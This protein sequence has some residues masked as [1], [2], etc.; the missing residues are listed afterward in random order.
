MRLHRAAVIQRPTSW[1]GDDALAL[2][3]PITSYP[4]IRAA[5]ECGGF[6]GRNA[7]CALPMNVCQLRCLNV[8]PGSDQERRTIIGDELAEDWAELPQ[9]DGIR[10]L[11]NGTG[12]RRK[13]DRTRST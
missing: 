9:P 12:A 13:S 2:E 7:I 6:A 10:F 5:L 11:G 8:P 4:E 1:T 3:Q